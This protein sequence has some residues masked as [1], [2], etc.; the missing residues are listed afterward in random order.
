MFISVIIVYL[1]MGVIIGRV[2]YENMEKP[3]ITIASLLILFWF[4][5][6]II[7]SK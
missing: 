4:P 5:H 2:H 3:S 1:M 6:L 7:S